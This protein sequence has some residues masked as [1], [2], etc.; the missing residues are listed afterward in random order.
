M[1]VLA[2]YIGASMPIA[3]GLE[4]SDGFSQLMDGRTRYLIE[5]LTL[6]QHSRTGG[7]LYLIWQVAPSSEGFAT[8]ALVFLQLLQLSGYLLQCLHQ[9]LVFTP[10]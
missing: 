8:S 6:F 3:L 10:Y 5:L 7:V 1:S 9:C 4:P 2:S